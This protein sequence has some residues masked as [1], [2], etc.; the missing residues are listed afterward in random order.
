MKG[1]GLGFPV[2]LLGTGLA[3]LAFS[4]VLAFRRPGPPPESPGAANSFAGG[5]LGHKAFLEFLRALGVEALRFRSSFFDAPREPLFFLEPRPGAKLGGRRLYLARAISER[6]QAGLP[7]VVVLPKWK[8]DPGKKTFRLQDPAQV[9]RILEGA[10]PD[11]EGRPDLSR[12]PL[13][14]RRGKGPLLVPGGG[15]IPDLSVDLPAPQT[16]R[17]KGFG[18][19][20]LGRPQACLAAAFPD[21]EGPLYVVADPDLLHNFNIH[22]GNHGTFWE[23][24]VERIL[25]AGRV[26]LDEVFHGLGRIPSL[27]GVLAAFPGSLFLVQGVLLLLGLAWASFQR[28]GPPL[29]ENPPGTGGP[30]V[31][32]DAGGQVLAAA[33]ARK[34][35]EMDYT[36]WILRDTAEGLGRPLPK[37]PPVLAKALDSLAVKRG[38]PPGAG[39]ALRLAEEGRE[40]ARRAW[41]FRVMLLGKGARG[42][43]PARKGARH[44]NR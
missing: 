38:V 4:L 14:W 32:V 3:S 35:V 27:T 24:F 31:L 5:P 2:L 10:F 12:A 1:R 23:A 13:P 6:L 16:L 29:K 39:E 43:V 7:T 15:G 44:G 8:W 34:D 21:R 18:Q 37:D 36:I 42:R 40:G 20:L 26:Y 9:A 25:R 33:L 30:G 22:R 11:K 17:L 19:V 28:F 41:E